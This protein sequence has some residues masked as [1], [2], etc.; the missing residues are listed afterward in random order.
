[1]ATASSHEGGLRAALS[2]N[3]RLGVEGVVIVILLAVGAFLIYH[4]FVKHIRNTRPLGGTNVLVTHG[5]VA[6]E[7]ETSFAVDSMRSNVLFGASNELRTYTSTDGGRTWRGDDGP[8]FKPGSCAHGE[9]RAASAGGREIIAFLVGSPCG[10]QITPFLAATAR[11]GPT[12]AWSA[13][14]RLAP[15][16]WKYGFDDAPAIAA[17]PHGNALYVSWTR[18][19][20]ANGAGIVVSRSDDAGRTWRA[21]VLVVPPAD[22][23]HLST[24]AV[25]PNGTVYV[26]GIDNRHGIWI[27][28]SR[29]DGRTFSAPQQAGHLRANPAATCALAATQ[30]LPKD[31]TSC[32]GP[33]PTVLATNDG[34]FVVYDDV[35]LNRTQDVMIAAV[36]AKLHPRFEQ[37]LTPPDRGK[38][39]QFFPTAALDAQTA[40]L[41]ACWYDTT[42][43]PNNH[44]AWFTCSASRDGR[45]WSSPERAAALPTHVTDLYTDL[46]S[47][48]GF[49]P[50]LVAA[51]GV[52]HPFWIDISS[53]SFTQE[54]ATASLPE[55]SA[56]AVQP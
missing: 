39:S 38:T 2:R 29:D 42:F 31:E 56:L 27:A 14:R 7:N 53:R 28:Q 10:D 3:R 41:W 50:S 45:R 11:A 33:D 37:P 48:N 35:G 36:D 6:T 12:G 43:D 1:V 22:Q 16:A 46:Q 18:S 52:G 49:S 55:R 8:A 20:S 54:I 24:I 5:H 32:A 34:A 51:D 47:G 44:R 15:P 17:A 30:P 23:A 26:A 9:P 13:L 21:P 25:A 19:L 40:V 4:F